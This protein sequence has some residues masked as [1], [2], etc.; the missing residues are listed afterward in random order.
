MSARLGRTLG[1]IMMGTMEG[2]TLAKYGLMESNDYGR[3]QRS[4]ALQVKPL[5]A[6]TRTT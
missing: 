3:L 2:F 1:D 5:I 4:I 6:R